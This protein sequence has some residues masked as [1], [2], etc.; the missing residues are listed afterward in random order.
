M[1]TGSGE[2]SLLI[3]DFV[4]QRER[5]EWVRERPVYFGVTSYFKDSWVE[6]VS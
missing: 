6:I 3:D 2:V 4:I 5:F 1:D